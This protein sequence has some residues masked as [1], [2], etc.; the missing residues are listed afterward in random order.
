MNVENSYTTI[1]FKSLD[2]EL[3]LRM[4][5]KVKAEYKA[6]IYKNIFC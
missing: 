4:I 5:S 1:K 6:D 2:K 3:W